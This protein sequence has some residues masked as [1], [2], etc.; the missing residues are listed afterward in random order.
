MRQDQER[1]IG[2]SRVKGGV[3]D[4]TP[5]GRVHTGLMYDAIAFKVKNVMRFW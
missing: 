3:Q 1:S 5:T 2:Y 4:D